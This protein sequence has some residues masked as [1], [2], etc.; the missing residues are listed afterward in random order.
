MTRRSGSVTVKGSVAYFSQ[1]SWVLSATIRENILFGHSFD[2]IFYERVLEACALGPDLKQFAQGDQTEVGEKGIGLSGG[3]R[4]RLALARAVYSRA[5]VYLL[6]DP[7][8]AVDNHV[9]A[10]LFK[11]VIGPTGLL[12]DKAR[13]LCTNSVAFLSSTDRLLML[14]AGEIAEQA[15]YDD[16]MDAKDSPLYKL[17]A[18][19]GKQG[20]SGATTPGQYS[21]DTVVDDKEVDLDELAE[22]VVPKKD[23]MSTA[24]SSLMCILS[25]LPAS[26]QDPGADVD[27]TVSLQVSRREQASCHPSHEG[28]D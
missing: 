8:C 2:P 5:D 20:Q 14:R 28:V 12:K 11:H 26:A 15:T 19:L 10:H 13:V 16:V 6:D 27:L 25:S 21:D 4:A 23:L 9:A 3:Q 22:K 18:G 7:L 17:I 24:T 1:S